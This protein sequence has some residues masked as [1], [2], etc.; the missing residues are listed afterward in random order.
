MEELLND[1]RRANDIID[2]LLQSIKNDHLTQ[3]KRSKQWPKHSHLHE[4]TRTK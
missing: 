1:Y 4:T 3:L 2:S